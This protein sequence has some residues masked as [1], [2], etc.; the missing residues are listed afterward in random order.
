MRIWQNKT[1][2][3][4]NRLCVALAAMGAFAFIG[5]NALTG[6][7]RVYE[8]RDKFT[9]GGTY[10]HTIKEHVSKRWREGFANN[11]HKNRSIGTEYYAKARILKDIQSMKETKY[12]SK[13]KLEKLI[14]QT[15]ERRNI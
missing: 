11:E 7:Y 9:V 4:F 5:F 12:F 1:Y 2:R 14:N 15:R 8:P 6:K 10:E 3:G 13:D